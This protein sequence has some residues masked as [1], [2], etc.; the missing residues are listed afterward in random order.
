MKVPVRSD[1]VLAGLM[2]KETEQVERI[3]II[4]PH[5]QYLPID[6]LRVL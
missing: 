1:A 3:R 4:A 5:C 2:C 6:R